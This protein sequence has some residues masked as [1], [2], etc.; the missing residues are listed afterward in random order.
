M[1]ENLKTIV[2]EKI[3]GINARNCWWEGPINDDT[4][5]YKM[6]IA[7]LPKVEV[8]LQPFQCIDI[9]E[10]VAKVMINDILSKNY[11][12]HNIASNIE[13]LTEDIK[14]G[15][16]KPFI[17]FGKNGEPVACAALVKI[18]E[19]DIE[20][21]RAACVP[22]LNGGN[23][24]L[25]LR[26]FGEW[27]SNNF[28][29]DSDILRAEIRTAKPT[30]EVPGGQATQVISLNK[31]GFKPTAMV[32]MFHHGVP[33]RQ[34][35]FLLASIIKDRVSPPDINKPL[36]LSIGGK[37]EIK[38]FNIFWNKTFGQNPNFIEST[39][40]QPEAVHLEAQISGPIVEIKTSQ[41]PNQID[42]VIED[43]FTADGR[44]A[45][46][47]VSMDLSVEKIS[48]ISDRLKKS[49]FQLAGFEP[50]L[51]NNQVSIDILFGKLSEI[52]KRLMVLPTFTERTFSHDEENILI[53]NS[54]LWRQI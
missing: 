14:Q 5:A 34:E 2:T 13:S 7:N 30:K 26:A 15:S 33:D 39:P 49:G 54:I 3:N 18:S 36:P 28:F 4:S 16:I 46:A 51:E 12:V 8:I 41:N 38:M 31:I 20:L 40:S 19:T 52:G 32:P 6:H 1:K 25:M 50:V 29:P 11:G 21:G 27:K 53:N 22:G 42:D 48:A 9:S 47:R 23:A 45:L 17:K 24:D 10:D 37:E 43:F 44:F 35:I